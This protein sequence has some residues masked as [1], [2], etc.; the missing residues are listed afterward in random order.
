VS[1]L[2]QDRQRTSNT[3][4]WCVRVIIGTMETQQSVICVQLSYIFLD[5]DMKMLSV[6]HKCFYDKFMSP[7]KAKGT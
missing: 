2:K 6:A 1:L 3:I 7:T 5:I 4:L